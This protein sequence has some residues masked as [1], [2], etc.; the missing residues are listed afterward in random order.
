MEKVKYLQ[1]HLHHQNRN[2]MVELDMCQGYHNQSY[3]KKVEE[4]VLRVHPQNMMNLFQYRR[5]NLHIHPVSNIHPQ[6]RL[7]QHRLILLDHLR[8]YYFL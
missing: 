1:H 7:L 3:S 6:I 4:F 2:P 8:M 5:L